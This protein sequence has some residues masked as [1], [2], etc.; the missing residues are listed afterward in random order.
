MTTKELQAQRAVEILDATD[1]GR[2][3]KAQLLELLEGPI[4]SLDDH[5]WSAVVTLIG[6]YRDGYRGTVLD[7]MRPEDVEEKR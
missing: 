2:A 1:R 6:L 5:G 3:V 4:C 7:A